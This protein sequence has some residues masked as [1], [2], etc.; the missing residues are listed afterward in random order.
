MGLGS[1]FSQGQLFPEGQGMV[2][3]TYEKNFAIDLPNTLVSLQAMGIK[4]MEVSNLFS[5]SII[6]LR[7]ELDKRGMHCPSFGVG[8]QDLLNKTAEV[9]AIAKT[10]EAEF[11]RVA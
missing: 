1:V 9:G 11:V 5:H 2:S 8:Y 10:L 6:D 4:D 7:M 3:Y